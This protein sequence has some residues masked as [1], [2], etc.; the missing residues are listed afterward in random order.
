MN[1]AEIHP[2]RLLKRRFTRLVVLFLG[3]CLLAGCIR[4]HEAYH[5]LQR[6]DMPGDV[7]L[8]VQDDPDARLLTLR[9]GPFSLPTH[10][11]N[12]AMPR[13]LLWS[14]PFDGWFIAY[15]PRLI[16][17]RG[18]ILRDPLLHHVDFFDATRSDFLCPQRQE[19]IFGSGSEMQDWPA[20]P[21]V[22]YRV[23]KGNA[24][25]LYTMLHNPTHNSFPKIFL[26][27][28]VEYRLLKDLPALESIYPAWF[29]VKQCDNTS[30]DLKPG[31][32]TTSGEFT[33]GYT[34]VLLG[35]GGHIHNYGQQL[36]M[37]NLTRKED[38][39]KLDSNHDPDGRVLSPIV[40]F[41][42]QAGYRLNRGE[43]I[44]VTATYDNP[45]GKILPRGGMGYIVGYFL[46]DHD[47][48]F[49]LLKRDMR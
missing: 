49:T 1:W 27:V 47:E 25:R 38:I 37:E 34:G 18:V 36:S 8:E 28:R 12:I 35:V 21:G 30:Y 20:L 13:E 2:R 3:V 24:I 4:Q 46:P 22:G 16:D 39:A 11:G 31:K 23:E 32:S 17:D 19:I 44:K 15:H 9:L 48:E 29:S 40:Y 43:V 5:R 14:V 10:A 41:N 7:K 6:D 33:M 45:T 42:E 26:E